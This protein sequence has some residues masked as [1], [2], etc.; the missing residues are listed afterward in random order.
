M[1][2]HDLEQCEASYQE[3][4]QER[5]AV[6]VESD[7]QKADR[8]GQEKGATRNAWEDKEAAILLWWTVVVDHSWSVEICVK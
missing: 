5:E 3:A 4:G 8:G 2:C 6:M 7:V 1:C